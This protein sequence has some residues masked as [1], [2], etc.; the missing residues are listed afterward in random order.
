MI[1]A[2]IAIELKDKNT[3]EKIQSFSARLKQNQ[4][5]LKVVKPENLH[6]T[7]K[8]LGNISESVALKIYEILKEDVKI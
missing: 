4:P 3:I 1:R 2:F 8:F 7:V 6:M 5:K